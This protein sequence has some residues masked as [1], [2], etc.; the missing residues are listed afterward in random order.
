MSGKSTVFEL[1]SFQGSRRLEKMPGCTQEGRCG[2]PEEQVSPK[3]Y[4]GPF[5]IPG[6]ET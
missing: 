3:R 2:G 1:Q 4:S 6:Q 5:G